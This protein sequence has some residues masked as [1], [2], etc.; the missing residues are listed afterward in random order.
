MN[1]TCFKYIPVHQNFKDYFNTGLNLDICVSFNFSKTYNLQSTGFTNI[2]KYK[3]LPNSK[4]FTVC[5]RQSKRANTI[6]I[7]KN[8]ATLPFLMVPFMTAMLAT[9]P[10]YGENQESNIRHFS[11]WSDLALGLQVCKCDLL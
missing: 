5:K 9:A 7:S 4:Q 10:L 3:S 1:F 6:S 11:A 2:S 8:L